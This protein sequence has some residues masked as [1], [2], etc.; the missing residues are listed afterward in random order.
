CATRFTFSGTHRGE[1][2]GIAPTNKKIVMWAIAIV[3]FREGRMAE[4]WERYDTATSM[5]ELGSR[6]TVEQH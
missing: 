2:A 1:L 5:R 4:V 6:A 3:R